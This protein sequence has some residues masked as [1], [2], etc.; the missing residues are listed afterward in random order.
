MMPSVGIDL[1]IGPPGSGRT[2]RMVEVARSACS[3]GKRVWW[4]G[5][6]AQRAY[7]LR[8]VTEGGY[9]ALGLEFMSAQQMFYR[10]LTRANR[11]Q[12]M[13]VGSAALVRVAE[14][15]RTVMRTFPAPGEARLFARAIAEA[16]RFGVGPAAYEEQAA[17]PEQ[18]RLAEVYRAYEELKEA[19]DYDDVRLAAVE[20]AAGGQLACEAEV[21]IVDGLREIGPL[22]LQLLTALAERTQVHV[23]L[24]LPP[25]TMEASRVLDVVHPVAVERYAAPN[26]VSEARWVMRSVK[27]DLAE[28]GFR[29]LDLAI[30]AAPGRARAVAAL[31]DEY[32]V[33]LMD[34]SP[35]ALVDR[36]LG[37]RLVDLLELPEH[38]T[39]ARLLAVD[40]L[41]PLAAAALEH[42]VAGVEAVD[43]LALALGLRDSWRGWL[44]RL[45]VE[46]DSV[47]W[48]R[49]LL[50]EVVGAGGE[51]P[52]EFEESALAKAQEAARLGA[53]GPGFR[54][55]WA[56]L[57]QDSRTARRE[58]AG[59]AL[60][61]ATAA[62]GRR[63][64][65]A[66]VVGAVEGAFAAGEGED[67]FVPEEQRADLA[68]AFRHNALPRRF[69]GR[70]ELVAAELLT[71]ADHLVITAPLAGQEGQL[72]PDAALLGPE[73]QELPE[74]PAAS[75]LELEPERPFAAALGTAPLGRPTVERLRRYSE[76]SFRL[77]GEDTLRRGPDWE[78]DLPAWRR[79][80]DALLGERNS[81]LSPERLTHLSA[82]FPEAAG[83]L[84]RHAAHLQKLTFNVHMFGGEG[85]ASAALHAA[86]REPGAGE[87]GGQ[88]AVLYR[89]VTPGSVATPAEARD[90]LRGRWTEYYA[91]YGLLSQSSH[92]VGR[93]DVVVWPV[94]GEPVSAHGRGV[95][96]SFTLGRQRRDWVND[97]LPGFLGGRVT[98]SPGFQ[99]R[100]CPVF[101]VCREGVS[102]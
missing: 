3:A 20:L 32:L 79:L 40:E 4:V 43:A 9:V 48:G 58:N 14:A 76:C 99:C 65:K 94:F 69:Q 95:G 11:L 16:K 61:T 57:L 102:Y 101:D 15:M 93:V 77:W 89:F 28:G 87:G 49:R 38:P 19:W 70:A 55:W 44:T 78:E 81:R 1:T 23:N 7:V 21:V 34:E 47:A 33:P 98:P 88:R 96:R 83:W 51:L 80:V 84:G 10:L 54:A 5:L 97:N 73:P 59:V 68:D 25:P 2:T 37:Q 72:V 13:F 8:R 39:A 67:Y 86:L 90:Y 50:Q 31:A 30:I 35:L 46:G 26:P 29:P 24:G 82:R 63:W 56:A 53:A 92:D 75:P 52:R 45:E 42:G 100:G 91:A 27:R 41:R 36:P 60:L 71:R 17:D 18:R 22:E 6:P 74:L 66:Y 12:P 64:R 85:R 62:S